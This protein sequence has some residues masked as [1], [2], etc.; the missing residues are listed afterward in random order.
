MVVLG[1]RGWAHP[2]EN[3]DVA[4]Y[5]ELGRL[6]RIMPAKLKIEAQFL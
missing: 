3:K 5:V 6:I 2:R 4:Y 1:P